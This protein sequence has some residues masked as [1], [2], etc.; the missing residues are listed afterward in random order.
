MEFLRVAQKFDDLLQIFLGFIDTRDVIERHAAMRFVEKLGFR[1]T[2]TH[3]LASTA[4]HLARQEN[5]CRKQHDHRQPIHEQ[6]KEPGHG[7]ILRL[8]GEIHALL[9]ELLHECRIIRR[10]GLE[11]AAIRQGS[12][13]LRTRNLNRGDP[14]RINILQELAVGHVSRRA[15]MARILEKRHKC[16]HQQDDDD[17]EREIPDI[18]VHETGQPWSSP[19]RARERSGSLDL[20]V[21]AP[22]AK[23]TVPG[24]GQSA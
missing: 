6:S 18:G 13:N 14:A 2:E 9:R 3:R 11:R 20:S 12:V 21:A 16:Q 5:P 4:L 22:I 10:I 15:A 19:A 1:F 7:F 23:G 24:K 17:P 8:R